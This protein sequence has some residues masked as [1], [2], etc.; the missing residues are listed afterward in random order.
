M[1]TDP[2]AD[3]LIQIKNAGYAKRPSV[4]IPF[5]K[6]KFAI[7]EL[8]K[9]KGYVGEVAKKGKTVPRFIS[10]VLLYETSGRPKVNDVKRISKPSRRLY[11]KAKNL[12]G[13]RSGY[14]LA[15]LS[16]PKGIM[17]DMDAK[18]ANVGGELLFTIW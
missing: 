3:L 11:E 14:G 4:T 2:I 9:D 12:Q 8:L 6:M 16:T 15:V 7:A 10:I 13:Y 17:T 1:T 18:K 5:S